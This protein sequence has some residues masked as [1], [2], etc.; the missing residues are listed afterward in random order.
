MYADT[1][2][3]FLLIRFKY[4]SLFFICMP[5]HAISFF[6]SVSNIARFFFNRRFF[7]ESGCKDTTFFQYAK[8]FFQKFPFRHAD[9]VVLQR[10]ASE[11]NFHTPRFSDPQN[12]A[13]R[14]K[15]GENWR[16]RGPKRC[17]PVPKRSIALYNSGLTA[18]KPARR[19]ELSTAAP[20]LL[21]HGAPTDPV[22]P[23]FSSSS[24]VFQCRTEEVLKNY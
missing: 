19:R 22:R 12:G 11:K 13:A 10:Y 9:S 8:I 24:V 4:R 2:Y 21:P 3:L 6:S 5:T 20:S 18:Q 14:A 7:G 17:F 16:R 15:K 23:F 1:R